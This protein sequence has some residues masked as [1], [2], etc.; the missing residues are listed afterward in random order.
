MGLLQH[1]FAF[2]KD[3]YMICAQMVE[4]SLV[5]RSLFHGRNHSGEGF[6]FS[7]LCNFCRK[8]AMMF[9]SNIIFEED[10][11]KANRDTARIVSVFDPFF[12]TTVSLHAQG[13]FS[14]LSP[15][16]DRILRCGG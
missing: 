2:D 15:E 10:L 7:M 3:I 4:T 13:G 9:S 16:L 8:N 6:S 12:T 14:V 11:H 5:M 1:A